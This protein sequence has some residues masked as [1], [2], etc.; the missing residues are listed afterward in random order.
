M[1]VLQE[2]KNRG[3]VIAGAGG[4]LA[5]IGFFLPY[6][7]AN[8]VVAS[9]SVS[10]F[11]IASNITVFFW[12]EF[13]AAVAAI[14]IPLVL[15]YRSN[16]FGFSNMPLDKQIRLGITL[17]I[18]AGALAFLVNGIFGILFNSVISQLGIFGS[19]IGLG[20]GFWLSLL[21]SIAVIVGGVMARRSMAA[22]GFAS[23]GMQNPA[24]QYPPYSQPSAPQMPYQQPYATGD[25]MMQNPQAGY[26]Q[27]QYGQ[28]PPQQP[29]SQPSQQYD[30]QQYGQPSQ[31]QYG[32]SPYPPQQIPPQQ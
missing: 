15:I 7:T 3:Y 26:N 14:A 16:A 31:Q 28:F 19:A 9:A 29:Y 25:Q 17:T 5:F 32:Q 21:A 30:Q 13:L 18:V 10:G 12:L 11:F 8:V 4:I 2:Q 6:V 24:T 1:D 22:N 23:V 27:S 20:F